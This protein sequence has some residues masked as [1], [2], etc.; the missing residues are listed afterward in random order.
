[1]KIGLKVVFLI[2][3][4][5]VK[6]ITNSIKIAPTIAIIPPTLSA[7]LLKIA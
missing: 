3:E 1:L 7:M 4:V 5:F 2:S 6:G